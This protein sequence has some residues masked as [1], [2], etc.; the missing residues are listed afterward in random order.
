MQIEYATNPLWANAEHT[1][2]DLKI[3]LV[4][5]DEELPFTASPDDCEAH[6]R[7]MFAAAVAGEYGAVADFVPYV[8]TQEEKA[9]AIRAERD[10]LLA[11]TDWTQ[12]PDV[13][14]AIR[15]AYAV[16]R[17]GLRD[18]PQQSGFPDVFEWPIKPE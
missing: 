17:Q 14:E 1:I 3:K 4:G 6:G 7:A 9:A 15:E 2:I 13:P 5:I 16:Y 12:L 18:V 10:A 11:A 8:P